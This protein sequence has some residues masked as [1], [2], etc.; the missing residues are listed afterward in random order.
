MWVGEG[1]GDRGRRRVVGER[2]VVDPAF[3]LIDDDLVLFEVRVVAA[4]VAQTVMLTRC[5]V[6]T[7]FIYFLEGQSLCDTYL[8]LFLT[9]LLIV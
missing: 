8:A 6:G 7:K 9:P 1:G 3:Q 5:E 4:L 2:G